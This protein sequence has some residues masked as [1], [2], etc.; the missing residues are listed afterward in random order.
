MV[1]NL[2]ALDKVYTSRTDPDFLKRERFM[3]LPSNET[4]EWI[5]YP[6]F[7]HLLK[8]KRVEILLI[9]FIVEVFEKCTTTTLTLR[10]ISEIYINTFVGLFS[11]PNSLTYSLLL[12]QEINFRVKFTFMSLS[13]FHLLVI[14]YMVRL[15]LVSFD[16]IDIFKALSQVYFN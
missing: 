5:H 9:H 11:I 13:N 3:I 15:S 4:L 8:D 12:R 16:L 1:K 14:F 7:L 2:I 10:I 6:S